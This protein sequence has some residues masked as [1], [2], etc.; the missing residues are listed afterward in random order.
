MTEHREGVGRRQHAFTDAMQVKS[1]HLVHTKGPCCNFNA[2]FNQLDVD[3]TKGHG[4]A[5][6]DGQGHLLKGS[7]KGVVVGSV[8]PEAK[9]GDADG[10]DET[11][12]VPDL[13]LIVKIQNTLGTQAHV[14][15]PGS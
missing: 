7:I 4:Q 13:E 6:R 8:G 12:G 11:L 3:R 2:V 5:G 10:F 9:V 15:C 1:S 14:F